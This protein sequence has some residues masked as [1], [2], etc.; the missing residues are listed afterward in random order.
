MT[1]AAAPSDDG[2]VSSKRTGSHSIGDASTF[3]RVMPGWC[4]WASGFLAPLSRS[5]TATIAPMCDGAPERRM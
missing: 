5:L 4:R 1:I 2:Q 3:S